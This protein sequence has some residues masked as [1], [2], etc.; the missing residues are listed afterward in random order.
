MVNLT[1][2]AFLCF[3]NQVPQDKATRNFYMEIESDLQSYKEVSNSF[4]IGE[5]SCG[6]SIHVIE[7]F[8]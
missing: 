6:T 7:I 8:L 4:M 3:Q 1:Q 2:P 5:K